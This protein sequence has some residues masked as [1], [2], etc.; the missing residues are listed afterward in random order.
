MNLLLYPLPRITLGM[1]AGCII[2][3]CTN[4]LCAAICWLTL[5]L[6]L[7]GLHYFYFKQKYIL[8][9]SLLISSCG[10]GQLTAYV[11]T[12]S[13]YANHFTH[14]VDS[15]Q[16][17]TVEAIVKEQLKST[18]QHQRYVVEL[19]SLDRSSCF[20]KL[21]VHLKTSSSNKP[22]GVGLPIQFEGHIQVEQLA[23]NPNAFRYD[24][25]L[26]RKNIYGQVWVDMPAVKHNTSYR[27]DA[28]YWA[29]Q[30][31]IR[32]SKNLEKSGC[33][34][35]ISALFKALFMGQQQEIPTAIT[36][37][38]QYAGVVHILSVSGLHV[39][40]IVILLQCIFRLFPKNQTVKRTELLLSILF[41]WGFACVAGLAPSVL[42]AVTMFS[43]IQLGLYLNRSTGSLHALFVSAFLILCWTP[44][45]VFDIGFQLSYA[46]LLFI[47]LL[48]P[49]LKKRYQP[50]TKIS[51]Y[52]W[53]N[54]TVSV[55]AQLGTLPLSLYYFH[56]F[57]GL[58]LLANVLLL[59]LLTL[60]M[61]VGIVC[62]V[63]LVVEVPPQLLLAALSGSIQLM[64]DLIA[65]LASFD[66]MVV[67][68][69]PCTLG[70][71]MA[72]YLVFFA[73]LLWINRPNYLSSV[74]IGLT[75]VALQCSLLIPFWKS[76]SEQETL[77]FHVQR[78]SAI[79]VRNGH[80]IIA[81]TNLPEEK[82][83]PLYA[84]AT[85]HFCRRISIKPL[86]QL[87]L[88]N[89]KAICII[90]PENAQEKLPLKS[91]MVLRN[92]PKINLDLF[93][94]QHQPTQIIADGSNYKSYISRWKASC[95]QAKIPFHATGEKGFY[96][97]K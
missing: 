78:Y 46:A 12:D 29:D 26:K 47:F 34:P 71:A 1:L 53:D 44:Q 54:C 72:L 89:G 24:V 6:I 35:V 57:P 75:L 27:M 60:V 88:V 90:S 10:L 39:G 62:L 11:H 25:Y 45:A 8:G 48:Q 50:D 52:I 80:S 84:Y 97:L 7:G 91:R 17:Q 56:Q 49:I 94:L 73:A 22:L 4:T 14:F 82:R 93:I 74:G 43:F 32:I 85:A 31:R 63:W 42:R 79:L 40:F 15:R 20:G 77:L 30:L 95:I 41:L 16:K 92:S 21:L 81:Y 67:Q 76:K 23:F 38:Y 68:N 55:S 58:F 66:E 3:T 51:A 59:P 96:D 69:I 61:G 33:D 70:M 86:P 9:I 64:N 18:K 28:N 2:G 5:P 36:K 37:E 19:L 83:N 13:N 65:W 87:G